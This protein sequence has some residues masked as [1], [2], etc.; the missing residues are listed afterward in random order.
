MSWIAIQPALTA[1]CGGGAAPST[2]HCSGSFDSIRYR[3]ILFLDPISQSYCAEHKAGDYYRA[4]YITGGYGK[5]VTRIRIIIDPWAPA[6]F[7]ACNASARAPHAAPPE[8]PFFA[9][10]T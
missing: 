2:P 5:E 8:I 7:N 6:S 3:I 4:Y 10:F 9:T 1:E